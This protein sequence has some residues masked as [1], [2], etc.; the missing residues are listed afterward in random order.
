MK[1]ISGR[2]ATLLALLAEARGMSA[3]EKRRILASLDG[4]AL[5]I[6]EVLV[7]TSKR[8]TKAAKDAADGLSAWAKGL[9]LAHS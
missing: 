4:Q 5:M 2:E 9:S 6:A 3:A 1:A 7:G 8:P